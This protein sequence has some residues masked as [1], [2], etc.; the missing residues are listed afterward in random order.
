MAPKKKI[1]SS[2]PQ[3]HH[4]YTISFS[5]T[6]NEDA[7]EVFA[8]FRNQGW[9]QFLNHQPQIYIDGQVVEFYSSLRHDEVLIC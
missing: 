1:F 8:I 3:I 9:K 4:D 6:T 7:L 2:E 5:E